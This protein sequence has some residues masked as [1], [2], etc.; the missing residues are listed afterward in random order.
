MLRVTFDLG[1]LPVRAEGKT[2][3][4]DYNS[5]LVARTTSGGILDL[6]VCRELLAQVQ[7]RNKVTAE[8]QE[9]M[10][11]C[12]VGS[13][14]WRRLLA[15]KVRVLKKLD[16]R[17]RQMEHVLTKLFAELDEVEGVAFAVV[18][19]LTDLRRSARTGMKYK[20]V[21]QKINQMAYDRMRFEQRYKN[22]MRG[23]QTDTWTEKNT[24][25][26]C[27]VCGAYNPV[28]RKYRGLWLCGRCRTVLQA[29]LNGSANL[30][31]QYLF[32]DCR[33]RLLPFALGKPRVW[34]W[35]GKLNKFVQVSSRAA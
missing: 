18:G 10:S 30:L 24:S 2:S 21:N 8:F 23:V 13:R 4:Y 14:R 1:V 11:R 34:R 6:F 16:R 19:D 27:C 20:K 26:V 7:Y 22:L 15:V 29:D 12:R 9:K 28:W 25:T 33:G 17:I 3:A 32:G 35:D 31:K 5:A